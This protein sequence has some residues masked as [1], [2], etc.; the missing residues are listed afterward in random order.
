MADTERAARTAPATSRHLH[1]ARRSTLGG[2]VLLVAG[3]SL[4]QIIR[5]GGPLYVLW[6]VQL[7]P[8]VM[9][10]PGLLRDNPRAYIGLCFVLLLYF[11]KGVEGVFHPARTWIDYLLLILS[12]FL[13]ITAMLTSRWLQRRSSLSEAPYAN[14]Q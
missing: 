8:L 7:I 5:P 12:V 1:L 11:I 9:F 14:S 2:L 4:W 13:F 10:V 3:L 6:V